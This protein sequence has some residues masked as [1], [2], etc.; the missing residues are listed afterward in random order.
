MPRAEPPPPT[1]TSMSTASATTE[2]A[3]GQSAALMGAGPKSFSADGRHGDPRR[4]HRQRIRHA[5]ARH[6]ARTPTWATRSSPLRST[7]GSSAARS[8]R[9]RSHASGASQAF[10]FKGDFGARP[11]A[12]AVNFLNDACAGTASHRPQPLC[13]SV[14]YNGAN[15]NQSAALM[16]AGARD[17]RGLRRHDAIGQRDGRS[18][19]AAEEPRADR[20]LHGRRRHLRAQQRQCRLRHAGHR[21]QPDQVH[22]RQLGHADRWIRPGTSSPPMRA[23]TGSSPAPAAWM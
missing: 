5:G 9:R 20:Q 7:A 18:W 4:S 19:V 1:A 2:T 17:L 10:A 21:R 12:V 15:T 22:R 14:T 13:D 8:P 16:S 11:H 6:L 23:A 3:T